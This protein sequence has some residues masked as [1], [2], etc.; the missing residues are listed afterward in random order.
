LL[1]VMFTKGLA[2]T[3][4][5]QVMTSPPLEEGKTSTNRARIGKIF[6]TQPVVTI[7][8]ANA[9]TVTTSTASVTLTITTPAGATLTCTA[10]PKNAVAGVDTFTG[11][12]INNPGTYTLTAASSGLT[13]AVTNSFTIQGGG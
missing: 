10:N 6:G 13:N 1:N 12:S 11:C 4:S 5:E 9:N 7:Q 3:S 8:D 2:N